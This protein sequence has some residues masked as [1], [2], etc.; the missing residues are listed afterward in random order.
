MDTALRVNGTERSADVEPRTLLVELLREQL[1]LTGTKV[2]CETGEC[3]ACTVLLDGAAVKS[4]MVLAVQADGSEVTTVEGLA[5]PGGLNPVQEAFWE[6][7]AVQ[8]GFAAPGEI[9][10]VT[11]LLRRNPDPDEA[12]IRA[13][14]D[15]NL[16]R[17]TGYHNVVLAVQAAARKLN[18]DG[19]YGPPDTAADGP[20][21]TG[22]GAGVRQK[23]APAMLRGETQYIGDLTL[24][25]M[26][27][28]A[29]VR[30]PHAHA[31]ITSIDTAPAE[32]MP[33]VVRVFTGSHVQ[34]L[35]P[36]P[37]IW[38][39]TDIESH[40]PPHPS[41]MVPGSATVLAQDRVRY[42]GEQ[43]AVVVAETRQ[44]A[45]DAVASVRV[46]YEP[47]PAV[48]EAEDAVADGAPQLHDTVP[49]NLVLKAFLGD[50]AATEQAIAGAE[51]VVSQKIRNQRIMA[52]TVEGRGTLASYDATTGD[53]TLWTNVQVLDPIRVAMSLYVLGIPYTK[54][55]LIAPAIGSSLGAK[56]YLF[57]DAPLLLWIAK[58]LGRPVKWVDSR[59]ENARSTPHGR[60]HVTYATLAGTRDGRI[61]AL[62]CRAF[63][64]LGAYPVINAPGTPRVLVARSVTGAY[65]IPNVSYEANLVFTNTVQVGPV[66]G[67]GRSEAIF[68]IER[69][70]DLFARQIGM[71]P[72]EVRRRN[73]VTP[74]QQP[75]D[76]RLG[77]VYD[78]GDYPAALDQAL[79]MAGY[80]DL[81]A[82]RADARA[83]GK[84]LGVG[85][86]SYVAVAAVGPSAKMGAA[87]LV[88]GTWGSAFLAVE[89]NGEVSVTTGAQPHGQSQETTFAQI[90]VEELGVPLEMVT[91]HH[92][93]TA[94]ALYF[95][96]G[97]YGTR[98]LS[99]EGVAIQ[100]A[101]RKI[102]E[103]ARRHAAHLFHCD[104]DAVVYEGGRVYATFAPD[105]A[106][107]T[108]QQVAF[109]LWLAWDLA[110]GMEPG[111]EARGYFDPPEF[112]YPFGTHVALVEVDEQT[113]EVDLVRY[114]AV[115]DFGT[116][117]NPKVVDG[118]THG[119]IVLG[120]GQALYEEVVY[121][122]DG[123]L[124][125]DSYST[126]PIA[127]ASRLPSFE[128]D[129]T[130]T[131]TPHNPLGAKGAGD[132]SNPAVAPA[133]VNAV[134]DALADLG[135]T[136]LDMPLRPDRVWRAMTTTDTA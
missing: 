14:L 108:L 100:N 30:S 24:P 136:H 26:L 53:Y 43:V 29:F 70:V 76:N 11:D 45:E 62:A 89:P 20:P 46:D 19:A 96:Q 44:Q 59:S 35:M 119:N 21:A 23:E 93:D 40:W 135:V 38:G 71:D 133:V 82:R 91:V 15:G 75:F 33:G 41:G 65:D 99:I 123:S 51:V 122:P 103:K 68:L 36:L 67:A 92:S 13:W 49:G 134:C 2:G 113:G 64:N 124:L 120:V 121:A 109:T 101:A 54:L 84:R 129:R 18:G 52:A 16:G 25:A 111:L 90:V 39:A 115:N 118:Q 107:M 128:L 94:G 48:V 105:Q 9:M 80:G 55:R 110:D 130:E 32:A 127:K 1:G 17:V 57:A 27:H 98:S 47:L 66:R 28:A 79:S 86:G 31:R 97:S 132:V 78:S 12:E 131:P 104:L 102:K 61:T 37:V 114:V 81:E 83:R 69:M 77:W 73:M 95:G 116:V 22:I 42:A 58:E 34:S 4:C 6:E 85:I 87:G 10:S 3:G 117:V 74:E 112:N 125:T 72:A 60:D 106:T 56:G 88:S 50:Q 8:D 7:H 63:N 5:P 126:Y